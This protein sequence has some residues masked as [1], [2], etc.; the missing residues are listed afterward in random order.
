MHPTINGHTKTCYG[1]CDEL[2]C[3]VEDLDY[4][5]TG[6]SNGFSSNA[7]E[8]KFMVSIYIFGRMCYLNSDSTVVPE[9]TVEL[10][11]CSATY[12]NLLSILNE[13]T[14]QMLWPMMK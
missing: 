12:D 9:T 11:A 13:M 7:I 6:H 3:D 5:Y 1:T 2:R 4:I 10:E 8:S 14:C